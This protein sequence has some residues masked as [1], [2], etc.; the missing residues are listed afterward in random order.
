M[1]EGRLPENEDCLFPR[2]PA[3]LTIIYSSEIAHRFISKYHHICAI[4]SISNI[5]SIQL[6]SEEGIIHRLGERFYQHQIL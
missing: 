4:S 6:F 3:A 1:S 2:Q 5:A